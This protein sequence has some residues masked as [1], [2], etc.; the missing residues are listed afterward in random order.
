MIGQKIDH[1]RIETLLGKGG[2]GTVY[3]AEDLNLARPVALKLIYPQFVNQQRY[4]EHVLQ[5]ARTAARLTHPSIA[6]I[7]N[8]DHANGFLYLAMEFVA[9]N[10]LA[11]T[12]G[13]LRKRHKILNLDEALLL[14]AQVADALSY[15]HQHGMLHR[16]LKPSN[17]LIK[18]IESPASKETGLRAVVTDFG[19]TRLISGD[20]KSAPVALADALP[21][22]SPEQ[23][24]GSPLD[25]RSDIY[26]LGTILYQLTTGILPFNITSTTEAMV[27]HALETP[28][29]PR[30]RQPAL[31]KSVAAIIIKAMAKQQPDRYQD[32]EQMADDL[33]AAASNLSDA[34]LQAFA[35]GTFITYQALT[36]PTD[37]DSFAYVGLQRS[38]N[39]RPIDSWLP[40]PE[41]ELVVLLQEEL[42]G[43]VAEPDSVAEEPP[44]VVAS[45]AAV[46]SRVQPET[47]VIDTQ[48]TPVIPQAPRISPSA[49]PADVTPLTDQVIISRPGRSPRAVKLDKD[50]LKIGRSRDNDIILSTRD[51]S[52][53]HARLEQTPSGWQ[54][55]DLNS[56]GGTYWGDHKLVPNVPE[57]WNASQSLRIGPYTL[58]WQLARSPRPFRADEE[59]EAL[60]ELHEIPLTGT[61]AESRT[62][63]FSLMV[64]PTVLMLEP[65]KETTVQVE[66]YNQSTTSEQYTLRVVDLPAEMVLLSQNTVHLAPGS[67]AKLPITLHVPTESRIKAG[68]HPY[69]II[70]RTESDPAE[71]AVISAR[72]TVTP[73]AQFSMEVWP[74]EIRNNGQCQVLVR[75]NGNSTSRMS[76][77]GQ[78]AEPSL[79]FAGERGQ[80]KLEPGQAATMTLTVGSDERPFFGRSRR[81]PFEIRVR[82][83]MGYAQTQTGQLVL[84]PLVP[85]WT[86]P[87]VEILLVVLLASLSISRFFSNS[88]AQV[89]NNRPVMAME[90][91][92][93]DLVVPIDATAIIDGELGIPIDATAV[94]GDIE[95]TTV[96]DFALPG[97]STGTTGESNALP[98]ANDSDG[99]GLSDADEINIYG[100]DPNHADSDLD[101]M[102]DGEEVANGSDPLRFPLKTATPASGST[103]IQSPTQPQETA[104]P[105]AVPLPE[106][107]PTAQ[108]AP[109]GD[110]GIQLSLVPDGT[111]WLS[112]AGAIGNNIPVQAGDL[113]NNEAVSGFFS[114]DLRTIPAGAVVTSAKLIF[115]SAAQGSQIEG[116]P[117]NDLDCLMLEATEFDLPLDAGDYDV[118]GFYIDCVS[119]Q[120]TTIDVLNDVRDGLDFDLPYLQIRISFAFNTDE[121]GAND[122]YLVRTAPTLEIVYTS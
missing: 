3:Q 119:S 99:D 21:Y 64:N 7:Y 49:P 5:Q 81:H 13:E 86:L 105:T 65:G 108:A 43:A 80:V 104:V 30:I 14:T 42:E 1:Y 121:D 40:L 27:M 12:L 113:A 118:F 88:N 19:M 101:G 85:A 60:T 91:I 28:I 79:H 45:A 51:V 115:P 100:T 4:H 59:E 102:T 39:A 109:S 10:S 71:T 11:S 106:A 26:S 67:R 62:S 55:V 103:P 16:N 73:S 66:L 24:I 48:H 111:G 31:P 53:Y 77:V 9:G 116:T 74:L 87:V 93:D 110:G 22:M 15:A 47:A 70:V 33:R 34:G 29:S 76:L 8:F 25:G 2:I 120:P 114:Y 54:V 117:F 69:Q 72:V 41:D 32:A 44:A 50:R 107:T 52:R 58:R 6:T 61:L 23:C 112:E 75:N 68:H 97:D 56:S 92:E 78:S 83:D 20:V 82:N 90:T 46:S 96:V 18:Q 98:I 89:D 122:L 17:I 38:Q 57:S 63:Q 36:A 37:E 35:P 84:K 94:V 95:A